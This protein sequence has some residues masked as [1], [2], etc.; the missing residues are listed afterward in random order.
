VLAHYSDVFV[1]KHFLV[2]LIPFQ[3]IQLYWKQVHRCRGM[4]LAV[5]FAHL[6]SVPRYPKCDFVADSRPQSIVCTALIKGNVQEKR[7]CRT[8]SE[9]T[10]G[11][12]RIEFMKIIADEEECLSCQMLIS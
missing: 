11:V 1:F 3:L 2:I 7:F 12:T 8:S 4:Y 6:L 10:K 5:N 9:V